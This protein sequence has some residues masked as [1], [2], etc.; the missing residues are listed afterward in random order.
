ML[1]FCL[2]ICDFKFRVTGRKVECEENQ[3]KKTD[4]LEDA[5]PQP[6]L[7]LRGEGT[8]TTHFFCGGLFGKF[9]RR[10]SGETA[11][12]SPSSSV[13]ASLRRN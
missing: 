4:W 10:Y 5:R 1:V 6:D 9:S 13:F 3:G 8:A 2:T 11:D 7:L 12:V